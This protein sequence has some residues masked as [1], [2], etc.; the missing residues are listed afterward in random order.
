MKAKCPSC[1]AD[2]AFQS[3]VSVF[4]VCSHCRSMLVRHDMDIESLGQMAQVPDDV[5]PLK[6]GSQGVYG[7]TRF[8]LIGRLKVAW[9]E[10]YWNE[11]HLLFED[12]RQGWLGEA[13]GFYMVSFEMKETGKVPDASKLKPGKK[14]Q[15]LPGETYFVDDIKE[16]VCV[17][18]EGE[19]PFRAL[20]GRKTT[21]VDL[22]DSAS[23]YGCIEYSKTDGVRLFLGRYVKFEDL[24]FANLRD[25]TADLK[26]VRSAEAFKCPSCG[27]PVSMLAPGH[28]AAVVCAYCGCTIDATN[29]NLRV[30]CKADKKMK[31]KPLIPIGSKG[32]LSGVHWEAIGFMRRTDATGNYFWDEY[33]LFNPFNGFRWLTTE[34]GH[35][36][37]VE[38]IRSHRTWDSFKRFLVGKAKVIY[39]LGEFYWRVK[40]G[41]TVS[42][43]DY[44]A[45]PEILCC[46]REET[47]AIWSLGSYIEAEEIRTA[48]GITGE[49]PAP[50]GVAPSQP[51]PYSKKT[52]LALQA[53]GVL[54]LVVTLFQF[55]FVFRA[56]R[57]ELYRQDFTFTE[58]GTSLTSQTF[59][60]PQGRANLEFALYSP[61][62]NGWIDAGIDLIDDSRHTSVELEQGVEY[63]SGWDGGSWSEG[64]QRSD[65]V[66]S[67]IPG[68]RYHLV[69]QPVSAGGGFDRS[70]T[71]SIRR[72]VV[73][74][75]N[76]FAVIFLLA[77]YPLYLWWR[78]RAFETARWSDS[79]FS[80]YA[81]DDEDE[82]E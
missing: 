76:Y 81:V 29:K 14:Y 39:V 11:W 63:Y 61:V 58:P 54:F 28:S 47:E 26:R 80:P 45:P 15:L 59:D 49:F 20:Q 24:Q 30:I 71:L 46:E 33:L 57:Q 42:V 16:A 34:N 9:D 75:S 38:M 66:L 51:S 7:G 70:F 69:V 3:S 43:E 68:G 60:I 73:I 50:V 44:I 53:F 32:T 5:S 13:L 22:S 4:G 36:N 17:A 40:T 41:D 8:S 78:N 72:D 79:D 1:G 25:L 12:G 6:I 56:A 77:P 48:F 82:G 21:S 64:S 19:L 37:Y 27:G 23:R 65:V 55:Y 10:G 31:I 35:W 62:Q 67:S 74:W 18:S 2:V 52:P